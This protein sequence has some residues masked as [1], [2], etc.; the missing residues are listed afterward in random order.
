LVVSCVQG[1]QAGGEELLSFVL[2]P[3]ARALVDRDG[4]WHNPPGAYFVWCE[5]GAAAKTAVATL[6][7][8]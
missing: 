4:R 2:E 8:A 3:E 7:V 5:A 6:A 1:V